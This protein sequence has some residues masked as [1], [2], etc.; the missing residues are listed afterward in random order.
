MRAALLG[1]YARS[2]GG[3]S[4]ALPWRGCADGYGILVS[5][6]MSQQTR[7]DV[8]SRY[9]PAWMAAFPTLSALA[10]APESA[11]LAAWAGLGYYSRARR[12]QA[13]AR[14]CVAAAAPGAAPA[15]PAGAAALR[16]LPG[17]GAYTAG[18]VA[19]IAQGA[20]E[21]AVDGNALR[22]CARLRARREPPAD[23]RLVRDAWR[24]AAALL[25]DDAAAA[26]DFNQAL[27]DLG[28]TVCTPRAPACGRC[29]LRA[30]GAC[31]AAA[32][33]DAALPALRAEAAEA[34]RSGGG[35][36]RGRKKPAAAAGAP[37]LRDIEDADSALKARFIEARWPGKPVK[38]AVPE[39]DL[40]VVVAVTGDGDEEAVWLTRGDEPAA[41]GDS[42]EAESGG[43]PASAPAAPPGKR[44]RA[45]AAASAPG[46]S[47]A[48]GRL[49]AGQLQPP[50]TPFTAAGGFGEPP[51]L[52]LA[53]GAAASAAVRGC[54]RAAG[55][56]PAAD[57]ADAALEL[58]GTVT[59]VFSHV[60]HR[61]HVVR[62]VVPAPL[63][64]AAAAAAAA[65]GGGG[66]GWVALRRLA[67]A[68]LTTYAVKA[69]FVGLLLHRQARAAA[70][71]TAPAPAAAAAAALQGRAL[72]RSRW[73]LAKGRVDGDGA[74]PA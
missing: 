72:L 34:A 15:L 41:A 37:P 26:G 18:A 70:A 32:L 39:R 74:A 13:A 22:V 30:T 56:P 9:W 1:W 6:I 48:G 5:E 57:A 55:W 25:P 16:A 12:L 49:L 29:P 64:A 35:A 21:P 28:A 36:G 27:M 38:K 2:S 50:S 31:A 43:E 44:R 23:A 58:A 66:G 14:A 20:R 8:V 19:S 65:G 60:I 10:S 59:H 45:P 4:R 40:V 47:A 69:L 3:A 67:D 53:P 24:W 52:D 63:P 62:A 61:L 54:L 33:A 11:V 51:A 46:A 71:P 73:A 68:G 17:V 42:G 7:A